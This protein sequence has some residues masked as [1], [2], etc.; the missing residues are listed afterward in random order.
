M[1]RL[2]DFSAAVAKLAIYIVHSERFA[3]Y[4]SYSV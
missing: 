2:A 3:H 4:F 1:N